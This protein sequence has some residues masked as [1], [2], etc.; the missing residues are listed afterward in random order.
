MTLKRGDIVVCKNRR[1]PVVRYMF[2]DSIKDRALTR[3][4]V[5]GQNETLFDIWRLYEFKL[6]NMVLVGKA[7]PVGS[8]EPQSS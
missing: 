5:D 1:S 8:K 7:L 4:L 6:H 2:L 3:M